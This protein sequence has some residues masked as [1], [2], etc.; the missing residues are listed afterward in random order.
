MVVVTI[1][2]F[3]V[4]CVI[5]VASGS[6]LVKNIA[7]LGAYLHVSEFIIGFM[8]MA[9]ATSL[10]ELFVG[11]SAALAQNPGLALGN[12]IGANIADATLVLGIIILLGRGITIKSDKTKGDALYMFFIVLL[13][14]VL[15][16]IG[17]ELS[18]IDGVILIIAFFF[19]AKKLYKERKIFKKSMKN[20]GKRFEPIFHTASFIFSLVLLFGSS[21]YVV[22]YATLLSMEL[23]LPPI[24]IGLFVVSLGT[25][26]PELVF[27]SKAVMQG[28]SEMALGSLIGSIVVNSTLVLGVTAVIMPI[29]ADFL[30]F[31]SAGAFMILVTFLFATFVESGNRLYVKEGIALIL[32]Y[33]F[34]VFIQFYI[35]GL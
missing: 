15:M 19:Y 6:L 4:A 5:L 24:F 29:T 12:V 34:F 28:H 31:A 8:L 35:K 26:L 13:P 27:G 25:T 16:W 32:L 18:R 17:N 9:V 22:Q 21:Y 3:L 1:L 10:P 7:K 30:I 23:F 2:L 33:V 20:H 11:I 14:L